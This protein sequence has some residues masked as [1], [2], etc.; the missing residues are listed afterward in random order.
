MG[1]MGGVQYNPIVTRVVE[2]KKT[3]LIITSILL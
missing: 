3:L 1:V 2:T